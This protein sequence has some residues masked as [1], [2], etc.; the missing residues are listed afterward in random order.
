MLLDEL[1]A[2]NVLINKPKPKIF[3][4]ESSNAIGLLV[5]SNRSK[6][7]EREI[8]MVISEFG[9]YNARIRIDENITIE[10]LIGFVSSKNHYMRGIVALNKID[11]NSD[12]EKV[13]G[14][15]SSKYNIEVLPISATQNINIDKLKTAIYRNL[16]IMTIY[17]KPKDEDIAKPL[18]LKAQSTV[19]EAA[20]KLHTEILD[21]LKCAYISGP[22]AKFNRQ[23]VGTEHVLKEGDTITF[24]KNR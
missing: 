9:T 7:S 5:E 22:S 6:L 16:N 17:L 2:L 11:L 20:A 19:G 10:E 13:A 21:N 8:Q 1:K 14:T 3:I 18:I 23:R 24:I 4:N 12:Y 15:L